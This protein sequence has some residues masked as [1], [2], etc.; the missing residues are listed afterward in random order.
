[1]TQFHLDDRLVEAFNSGALDHEGQAALAQ[2][3]AGLLA[4]HWMLPNPTAAALSTVIRRLGDDS[5][6]ITWLDRYP[7]LP[8]LVAA[9]YALIGLLDGLSD[10]PAVVTALEEMRQRIGVPPELEAF[11]APDTDSETLAGLAVQ[12]ESLLAEEQYDEAVAVAHATVDVLAQVAARAGQVEPDLDD[13]GE[14]L[15]WVDRGLDGIGG[16]D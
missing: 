12:I 16:S 14:R 13:V 9:V 11:L 10:H 1:M 6:L 2:Q 8:R 4:V 15:A 5:A 7:G 3:V